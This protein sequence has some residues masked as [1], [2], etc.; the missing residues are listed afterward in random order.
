MRDRIVSFGMVPAQI[1]H[2]MYIR[3]MHIAGNRTAQGLGVVSCS[4]HPTHD[5]ALFRRQ[6]VR[7]FI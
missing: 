4:F 5:I 1:Q 2:C 6:R 7:P 3:S